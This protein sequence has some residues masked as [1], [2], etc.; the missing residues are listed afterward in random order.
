MNFSLRPSALRK[1]CAFV[2]EGNKGVGLIVQ[3]PCCCPGA[4]P[5]RAPALSSIRKAYQPAFLRQL[6]EGE[7]VG[8]RREAVSR[9][10]AAPSCTD[11]KVHR[12]SRSPQ[13]GM[14]SKPGGRAGGHGTKRTLVIDQDIQVGDHLA[15]K[16]LGPSLSL[17]SATVH[18]PQSRARRTRV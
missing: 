16:G 7:T 6:W 18:T 2:P 14:M 13:P 17:R 11:L 4:S 10:R 9:H 3:V 1:S 5:S 15:S 12:L 8:S